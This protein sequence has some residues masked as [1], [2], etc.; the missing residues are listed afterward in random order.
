MKLITGIQA[1][2]ILHM[3]TLNKLSVYF[4]CVGFGCIYFVL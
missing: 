1:S 2:H 3:T 4:L